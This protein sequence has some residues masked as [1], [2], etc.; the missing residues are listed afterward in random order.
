MKQ[1]DTT[2]TSTSP[3]ILLLVSENGRPPYWNSTSG[4]DFDLFIV[5][6]MA[7][8]IGVPPTAHFIVG[9]GYRQLTMGR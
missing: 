9:G 8:C 4:F 7:N 1:N 2:S 6:G 3:L 5:I